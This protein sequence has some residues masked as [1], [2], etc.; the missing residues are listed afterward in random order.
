M[1]THPGLTDE[2]ARQILQMRFDHVVDK[3]HCPPIVKQRERGLIEELNDSKQRNKMA[4][5]WGLNL[6]P[7]FDLLKVINFWDKVRYVDPRWYPDLDSMPRLTSEVRTAL[8]VLNGNA[9]LDYEGLTVGDWRARHMLRMFKQSELGLTVDEQSQTVDPSPLSMMHVLTALT[10]SH[11]CKSWDP[12]G[13]W[14]FFILANLCVLDPERENYERIE[15]YQMFLPEFEQKP[16]DS[17]LQTALENLRHS[18][19]VPMDHPAYLLEASE[20]PKDR[21]HVVV[22]LLGTGL[23]REYYHA[24]VMMN[25][26]K[27]ERY[28]LP[29]GF[30]SPFEMK[31]R[32]EAF[33]SAT[34]ADEAVAAA[35]VSKYPDHFAGMPG[36]ESVEHTLPVPA[37]QILWYEQGDDIDTAS[38][39]AYAHTVLEDVSILGDVFSS[40]RKDISIVLVCSPAHSARAYAE[41]REGFPEAAEDTIRVAVCPGLGHETNAVQNV[42]VHLIMNWMAECIKR[43]YMVSTY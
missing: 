5:K 8:N 19:T 27:G 18:L 2:Q 12:D 25:Q 15:E 32:G 16:L 13:T 1:R 22:P 38:N 36:F 31:E 17:E 23:G 20:L 43:L 29:L 24:R 35:F 10:M 34:E 37:G 9:P 21:C 14:Q 6:R 39:V 40:A 30:H 11:L 3:A 41:F 33:S 4:S 7:F 42:N 28:L 26:I